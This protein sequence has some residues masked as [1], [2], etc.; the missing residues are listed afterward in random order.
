MEGFRNAF[1]VIFRFLLA[2]LLLAGCSPQT[3]APVDLNLA[4]GS[5][6]P[7]VIDTDMAADD[8]MAILYLLQRPDVEVLAITVSGTGEAHCEPGVR[9]A[10]GL[11]ALAG[12]DSIRVACGRE[13]PL[14]GQHTFPDSW[15]TSVDNLL[16]LSLPA[17]ENAAGEQTA[18]DLLA[19]TLDS[20]PGKAAVLTLGPM[21]NLAGALQA[22][23]DLVEKIEMVYVM[24]GAVN[25][26]GN[27]RVP[28]VE[29]DN[30]VAEWNIYVDPLA[31][32]LV[33]QSGVPVTLVGLDAT[34]HVPLNAKF[35]QQ[36]KKSHATPAADFVYQVLTAQKGF[37]DSGG[38]YFWDP[39]TA[40]VLADESLATFTNK[41]LC[42]VEAEGPES[43]RTKPGESCPQVRVAV[44]A[45]GDRFESVFLQVLNLASP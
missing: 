6:H 35:Y 37:I 16:G 25:V 33:F 23:P 4:G 7:V 30:A 5:P 42:V 20:V 39:L 19:E 17:G 43:G 14:Q 2:L 9:N 10:L 32:N 36:V 27:L 18:V 38:Y 24:G 22:D 15:R 40:A 21:T 28:G 11:A 45:D 29:I 8:W 13:T 1:T 12:R 44:N 41:N 34:N 3:A 26:P 31:A